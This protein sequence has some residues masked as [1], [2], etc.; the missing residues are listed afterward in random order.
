MKE[1]GGG[2]LPV[3][4]KKKSEMKK[5]KEGVRAT[6]VCGEEKKAKR[7]VCGEEKKPKR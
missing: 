1:R 6:Y 2:G 4:R 7:Y 5:K 3:W